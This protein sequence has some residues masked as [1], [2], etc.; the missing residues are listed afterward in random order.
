[1]K[2]IK[3]PIFGFD[4]LIYSG[5]KE[6]DDFHA[7][8]SANGGDTSKLMNADGICW[9]SILYIGDAKDE[10]TI[11]HEASHCTDHIM[12]DLETESAEVRAYFMGWLVPEIKRVLRGRR[13]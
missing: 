5:K 10:N 1:M 13:K 11:I 2:Q 12:L 7:T 4:I 6:F 8:V 3:V 9:S